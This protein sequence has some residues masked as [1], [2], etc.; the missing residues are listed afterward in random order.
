MK[1]GMGMDL[2]CDG[3]GKKNDRQK[4]G[5]VKINC[6]SVDEGEL[7]F[8]RTHSGKSLLDVARSVKR[9]VCPDKNFNGRQRQIFFSS[10]E[11]QITYRNGWLIKSLHE[12]LFL[13]RKRIS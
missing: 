9:Q 12:N 6:R 2:V 11:W 7:V 13:L 10:S 3:C 8:A 4:F 1:I 5:C